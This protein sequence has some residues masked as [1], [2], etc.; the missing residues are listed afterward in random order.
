MRPLDQR[1]RIR[2]VEERLRRCFGTGMRLRWDG[3]KRRWVVQE[4]GR[5]TGA[6]NYVI[7][8]QGPNGEYREP[9]ERVLR[10]LH[11]AD[12]TVASSG[13][14][15]FGKIRAMEESARRRRMIARAREE[16]ERYSQEVSP[17]ILSHLERQ[18]M[19]VP[20]GKVTAEERV[21]LLERSGMRGDALEAAKEVSET[22]TVRAA[23]VFPTA[24]VD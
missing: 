3:T 9:D 4:R 8:V 23:P 6:W 13:A 24:H 2:R 20:R 22:H 15:G 14:I 16:F 11:G 18:G 7:T 19:V 10:S 1:G 21:A 5:R 17:K 12:M